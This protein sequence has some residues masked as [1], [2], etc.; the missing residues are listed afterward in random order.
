MSVFLTHGYFIDEDPLE[1]GIMKPY[2]PLGLLYLS[3]WLKK[4]GIPNEVYDTTFKSFE[5]LKTRLAISKPEIIGIYSTLMTKMNVIKIISFIKGHKSLKFSRIIIGGPDSR[6]HSANYLHLGVDVVIPGEGEKALSETIRFFAEDCKEGLS[7]ITGIIFMKTDGEIIT[8][9]GSKLINPE[10]LPFPSRDS[11]DQSIYLNR[12]KTYHGYSS[13]TINTMRGCPYF[14]HWCSKSVFGNT[15]TRR[16]PSDVVKEII[17]LRDNYQL[18][19][20]WFTD[21]VFTISREW[22]KKFNLELSMRNVLMPYEC[23]SR[24]DCLDDEM[25]DLLKSSG[26]RKLW[27][28][29]ESGSQKVIDQMNRRI[30]IVH[31]IEIM[32]IAKKAGIPTG[33]FIMLGYPG[34][35]KKDILKT[36]DFLKKASPDELTISNAYPI[37]GTKFYEL[38]KDDLIQPYNWE[39]SFE[40]EIKFLKQYTDR[41]YRFAIRY[42]FN[43][44]KAQNTNNVLKK[45]IFKFKA[46]LAKGFI[47]FMN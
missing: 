41:F 44:S 10:E 33:T 37:A 30:D 18:H 35:Q 39:K 38:V 28:G 7:E 8:T 40:K 15:Y 34:E 5:E 31:T 6:H 1:A 21:D 43:I 47:Y 14:C 20:V 22:M 45:L 27:I 9:T 17:H 16:S 23:I 4:E 19:Q 11:I 29:A 46:L 12:W 3:A 32:K 42:L 2:P 13:M 24:S 25:L 26:C 36:A